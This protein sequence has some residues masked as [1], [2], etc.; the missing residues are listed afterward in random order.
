MM[1]F[2]LLYGTAL[3]AQSQAAPG[4]SGAASEYF[5]NIFVLAI[6]IL[7]FYSLFKLTVY[8]S[9]LKGQ[10]SAL[11]RVQGNYARVRESREKNPEIIKNDLLNGVASGSVVAQRVRELHGISVYGG[12]FDQVALAEVL[13]AREA[14]KISIAKYVASVLVLLGLCGAIWGLSRLV[15]E[16]GPAL[17]QV[18]EQ[19]ERADAVSTPADPSATSA[20]PD[21]MA[22]VQDS[23]KTLVSTM[24]ST[25]ANTRSAFAASLTGIIFSVL[26]LLANWWAGQR[27]VSFL[28]A[29]EDLTATR[30]IPLFKPPQEAAELASAVNSFKEGANYLV[31]LSD[32]LDGKVS[33]VGESLGELF[34][35][36]RKFRDSSEAMR[37]SHTLVHEAQGQMLG[38]VEQFVSLTSKMEAHQSEAR[39]RLDSVVTAVED[40]NRN[41]SRAIDGWQG[42]YDSVLQTI[43]KSSQNSQEGIAAVA[44]YL[45][46]SLEKHLELLK[47]ES[48]EMQKEQHG[49]NRSHLEDVVKQQSEFMKVLQDA[50]VSS[51]GHKE[52]LSGVA[53]TMKAERNVF[54]ERLEK[55]LKQNETGLKAMVAEQQKLIN[56]SGLKSV[57]AVMRDFIKQS[58]D[59]FGTM[60]QKQEMFFQDFQKLSRNADR[61]G[62]VLS[63]LVGVAA[64]TVPVFAT[65][66]IMYIFDLRPADTMMRVL[67]LV[68]IVAVIFMTAWFLRSRE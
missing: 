18:Q 13:A 48:I 31:R 37:V 67:S 26:L 53:E 28:T 60:L 10:Q 59:E 36:V 35:V 66:G 58:G 42:N 4:L 9:R 68:V 41:I 47:N 63:V 14:T 52:L 49:S 17:N 22:P 5:L 3:A 32:D 43:Q 54:G 16:M 34:S 62:S 25:L 30:L 29:L 27:Q 61:L 8:G 50:V 24:S 51:N 12:D 40:S 21:T 1:V 39:T 56:I 2:S 46:N 55:M 45:K 64:V 33:Q 7:F 11:E 15:Y 20:R 57:E 38:V 19:M 65:L 23:F 6:W 44:D